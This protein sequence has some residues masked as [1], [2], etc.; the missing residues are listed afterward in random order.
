MKTFNINFIAIDPPIEGFPSPIFLQR[1]V[2]PVEGTKIDLSAL[3][4]PELS[5][6]LVEKLEEEGIYLKIESIEVEYK[7]R[8]SDDVYHCYLEISK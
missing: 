8:E 5:D 2:V 4:D 1:S 3:I 7:T 6:Q